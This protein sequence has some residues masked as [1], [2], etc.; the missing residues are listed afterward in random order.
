MLSMEI[1]H[2]KYVDHIF[3]KLGTNINLYQ[4]ICREQDRTLKENFTPL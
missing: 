4:T 1:V 3:M 2:S